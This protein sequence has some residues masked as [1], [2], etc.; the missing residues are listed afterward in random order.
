MR[1]VERA[2]SWSLGRPAASEIPEAKVTEMK[3]IYARVLKQDALLPTRILKV[4]PSCVCCKRPWSSLASSCTARSERR[5]LF[6]LLS[7]SL[8]VARGEEAERGAG[9][10]RAGRGLDNGVGPGVP[11]QHGSR[12]DAEV[13]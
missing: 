2:V 4:R 9:V 10:L 5:R 13:Q 12:Q 3:E 8:V 6:D 7:S 1:Q 11:G